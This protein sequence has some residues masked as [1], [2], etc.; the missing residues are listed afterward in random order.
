LGNA[1][2]AQ[3]MPKT[4]SL[5][6]RQLQKSLLPVIPESGRGNWKLEDAL[7]TITTLNMLV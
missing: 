5:L 2:Q 6:N 4:N 1:V 3:N 7:S